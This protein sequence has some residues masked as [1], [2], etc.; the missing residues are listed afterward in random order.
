MR[1]NIEKWIYPIIVPIIL[2][3]VWSILAKII[4]NDSILPPVSD[5]LY[6]FT[7]AFDNF[8]GLGSLPRNIGFS[9]VR[10]LL[11]YGL[12]VLVAIPL[13]LLIGYFKTMSALFESFINLFKPIPPLAWQPLILGWFGVSSIAT[14]FGLKYGEQFVL[15]DN[16]KISMIFLIALG[17]FFPVIGNV[18]FG[19]RNVQKT[20]IESAKVLG[21]N[22]KDIFL[23]I[24]LPASSPTILNGLRM[25]LA[26]AWGCLVGAEMLPGSVSGV[27]YLITHAYELARIDLVITG[28]I[29]IGLVGALLDGIFKF[30]GQ[31]YFSWESKVK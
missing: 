31:R 24:L 18:I 20:L 5:I 23:N 12:G 26:T 15:W 19:V 30:I 25:G 21:A 7:H 8:I 1:K 17:S 11:G 22:N 16:Y 13:G 3:I 28:I 10:V 27:G 14:V 29:C 6:N 4:N 2:L 9:L